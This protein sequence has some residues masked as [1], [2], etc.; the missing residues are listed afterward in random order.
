M[1]IT[2]LVAL[3]RPPPSCHTRTSET[4]INTRQ[5]ETNPPPVLQRGP[6]ESLS[7]HATRGRQQIPK[8]TSTRHNTP[9]H[10]TRPSTTNHRTMCLRHTT[11]STTCSS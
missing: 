1:A 3:V 5:N 4:H 9:P 7:N 11:N 6:Q 10:S 8:N 2:G